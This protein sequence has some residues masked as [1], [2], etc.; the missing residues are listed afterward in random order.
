[1]KNKKAI[2]EMISYVILVAMVLGLSIGV[3]VWLKS[4]SNFSAPADCN[5]GTSMILQESLCQ[6]NTL[7][8][9]IK[10]NG[11][12]NISGVLVSVGNDTDK[13]PTIYF[14]PNNPTVGSGGSTSLAGYFF[15]VNELKPEDTTTAV[16]YDTY[17]TMVLKNIQIQPF[18]YSNKK[19]IFCTSSIIKQT[20]PDCSIIK[21]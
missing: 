20:I 11:R 3:F 21:V 19:R 13:V 16:F 15:F 18:I 10:N 2:S 4:I 8:L 14:E 1:M 7:N 6:G 5:E 17:N 9:T 12:F